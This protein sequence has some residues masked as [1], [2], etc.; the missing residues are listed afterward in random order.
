MRSGLVGAAPAWPPCVAPRRGGVDVAAS[1]WRRRR[2][3]VGMARSAS[4]WRMA[5]R[6]RRGG[7]GVGTIW[8]MATL[9]PSRRRRRWP[10]ALTVALLG[11]VTLAITV[12]GMTNPWRYIT[13]YPLESPAVATVALVTGVMLLGVALV[14]ATARLARG[15]VFGWILGL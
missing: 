10:L 4:A 7:R 8:T 9:S 12:T 15:A 3:G 11:A 6:R 5:W 14:L 1:T 2:G 13:L